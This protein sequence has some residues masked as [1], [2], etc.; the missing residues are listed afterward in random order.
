[1]IDQKTEH[2]WKCTDTP[3]YYI[4]HC[5]ATGIWNRD[6]QKIEVEFPM[7][8]ETMNRRHIVKQ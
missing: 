4:C 2:Y 6:L 8:Y 5:G 7:P 3:G 1:M